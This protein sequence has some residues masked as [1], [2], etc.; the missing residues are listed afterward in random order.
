MGENETFEQ[1]SRGFM[2]WLNR[3]YRDG[4]K[5]SEPKFTKWNM[6]VA[7]EAGRGDA[8]RLR[9]ALK[10]FADAVDKEDEAAF[11]MGFEKGFDEYERLWPFS[12]GTM[13]K[14][15]A[16][17]NPAPVVADRATIERRFDTRDWEAS[18]Y[19]DAAEQYEKWI[20]AAP[21]LP[22]P[23][24]R[25]ADIDQL[26]GY[27]LDGFTGGNVVWANAPEHQKTPFREGVMCVLARLSDLPAQD[28]CGRGLLLAGKHM[29]VKLA[30]IYQAT[31]QM[32][33]D[34]QA[35]RDWL[36]AV[37]NHPFAEVPSIEDPVVVPRGLLGAAS[38]AIKHKK[39]APQILEE[40]RSFAYGR[41][42]GSNA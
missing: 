24:V 42:G 15:S 31:G 35:I 9:E 38:H 21:A 29:F 36:E 39:D 32:M 17:L 34:C 18:D 8:E 4:S 30:E 23:S 26:A 27:F 16:A 40:L 33:T 37:A 10:P 7:Y 14:A 2:A 6:E 25:K 11:N 5:G 19:S 20:A 41:S 22:P 12:L 13:R 28:G 1:H 3:A